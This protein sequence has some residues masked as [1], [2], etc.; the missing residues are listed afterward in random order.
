MNTGKQD[1][2]RLLM[3]IATDCVVL[4]QIS[5]L[6]FFLMNSRP[7]DWLRKTLALPYTQQMDV[8]DPAT[9]LLRVGIIKEKGLLRRI[10]T[11]W[12]SAIIKELPGKD[13]VPGEV[14]ELGSGGG[15][16]QEILP[17]CRTSEV[18]SCPDV[19]LVV[20]ARKMPLP[21]GS[22]RAIT[23]VDVFHHIPDVGAFLT[24]AVRTLAPGGVVAMIEPWSTAWSRLVYRSLHSEPFEPAAGTDRQDYGTPGAWTFSS[25]GPLSGANGALPWIVFSR[26][27]NVFAQYYPSLGISKIAVGYPFIY[28]ASG[29]VSM[30]SLSPGWTYPF[31]R[32]LEKGLSPLKRQLGMF[33]LI[34]LRRTNI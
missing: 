7:I 25:E 21:D 17:E 16:F 11:S 1:T 22:L 26:D 13:A 9:T 2:P 34:V 32:V 3:K 23:M 6:T 14:L 19:E 18:F 10:Y 28:L 24:E 20:D 30:R 27:R 5:N 31:W 4:L 15:F 12:Y 29:G 8:D 33:A